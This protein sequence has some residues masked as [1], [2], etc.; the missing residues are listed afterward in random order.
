M[1]FQVGYACPLYVRRGVVTE[2][3]EV[4]SFGMVLFE[5]LTASPPAFMSR[6]SGEGSGQIQY[7]AHRINGDLQNALSLLDKKAAWPPSTARAMSELALRCTR[8]RE[9][10]RPNFAEI[11]PT[12]GF[13]TD[14]PRVVEVLE[15]M[16]DIPSPHF[17][18]GDRKFD[19]TVLKGS[20][21]LCWPIDVEAL[22][23]VC[24]QAPCGRGQETV[25]DLNVRSVME[26]AEV[27]VEWPDLPEVLKKVET[28]LL[29]DTILRAEFDKLLVYRPGD[30]FKGHRDS[31]R[32]DNHVATLIAIAGC[33]HR[34]GAVV[35]QEADAEVALWDGGCGS[36]CCWLT[37]SKHEIR[38][39]L[40]GHRIVATYKVFAEPRSTT[41]GDQNVIALADR[42]HECIPALET[43][44]QEKHLRDVGFLLHHEYSFDGRPQLDFWRLV[45][46]DRAL[47]LAL[48]SLG[49]ELQVRE[50]KLLHE[51]FPE[52][53]DTG[54][55]VPVHLQ[56]RVAEAV[57]K[58]SIDYGPWEW[59]LSDP[60][61]A[62]VWGDA[63]KR[64]QLTKEAAA[65]FG[66]K[67]LR[68]GD[69]L[70]VLKGFPGI[71]WDDPDIGFW[72]VMGCLWCISRD[73]LL[74]RFRTSDP[75][76][77]AENLWGNA[78]TF[79]IYWYKAAVLVARIRSDDSLRC[80]SDIDLGGIHLIILFCTS[81]SLQVRALRGIAELPAT[82]PVCPPLS[83]PAEAIGM[84]PATD[85]FSPMVGKPVQQNQ[86]K[87]QSQ[88][89]CDGSSELVLTVVKEDG[90]IE[91]PEGRK[92]CFDKNGKGS[93]ETWKDPHW[94]SAKWE[95]KE[96]DG[97]CVDPEPHNQE[98]PGGKG[99]SQ[100]RTKKA[101]S[102]A[103]DKGAKDQVWKMVKLDAKEKVKE[104]ENDDQEICW[105]EI[106]AKAKVTGV[107]MKEAALDMGVAVK[108]KIEAIPWDDIQAKASEM[109][110]SMKEAAKSIPWEEMTKKAQD[111]PWDDCRA[112]QKARAVS[113]FQNQKEWTQRSSVVSPP[114][115]P[116]PREEPRPEPPP[117]PAAASPRRAQAPKPQVPP[118]DT[119]LFSLECIRAQ[120]LL[121]LC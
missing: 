73:R 81:A 46:R 20:A 32:S 21:P 74:Q 90:H 85:G 116:R 23:D 63:E 27:V 80:D 98:E 99:F 11:A 19:V 92:L 95:L 34:G 24:T 111:I 44:L 50:V 4:Y 82:A 58:L 47:W 70:E 22:L 103:R 83:T 54:E 115:A 77:G 53:Y 79:S 9:E 121:V 29:P 55:A 28:E 62:D 89:S 91:T 43:L 106:A 114:P 15:S 100:G 36:W 8:L 12:S 60:E 59:L 118:S 26:T 45:G 104:P 105:D 120:G 66:V 40:E 35:F 76:G 65:L 88:R 93:V 86:E 2:G 25:L 69:A 41:P 6:K 51:F 7:L 75:D 87:S 84:S 68:A 117:M 107:S 49:L 39:I 38:P 67:E 42:L 102:E 72:P 1:A 119:E 18:S 113:P 3:S 33:P 112:G 78:G 64:V 101:N 5:L 48:E 71:D 10:A 61:E 16:D 97:R 17:V 108:E 52:N 56:C 14:G 96:K 110:V 109:G 37:S 57:S 94:G 31:K 30:F 13:V